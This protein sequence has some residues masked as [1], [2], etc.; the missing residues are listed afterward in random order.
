MNICARLPPKNIFRIT[1]KKN[2]KNKIKMRRRKTRLNKIIFMI[3]LFYFF[4]CRFVR[5]RNSPKQTAFFSRTT[6][7]ISCTFHQ[8][9]LFYFTIY[10]NSLLLCS[11]SRFFFYILKFLLLNRYIWVFDCKISKCLIKQIL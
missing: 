6:H 5:L 7:A 2:V 11:F 1:K 3:K 10:L 9:F 8:M 4:L